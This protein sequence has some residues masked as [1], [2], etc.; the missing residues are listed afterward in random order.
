MI[1]HNVSKVTT[2]ITIYLAALVILT[3]FNRVQ[4]QELEK[5]GTSSYGTSGSY[6]SFAN[7]YIYQSK[8]GTYSVWG[9][10][11]EIHNKNGGTWGVYGF[12]TSD[13]YKEGP[14]GR[15]CQNFENNQ[16]ICIGGVEIGPKCKADEVEIN[17]K[18]YSRVDNDGDWIPRDLE[19]ELTEKYAPIIYISNKDVSKPANAE[20]YIQLSSLRYFRNIDNSF[21][22]QKTINSNLYSTKDLF[23]TVDRLSGEQVIG[24]NDIVNSFDKKNIY[25]HFFLDSINIV[26]NPGIE[27]ARK[28]EWRIYSDVKKIEQR[29]RVEYWWFTPYNKPPNSL[30]G[31]HEG[32]WEHIEIDLSPDLFP[33]KVNYAAHENTT[34]YSWCLSTEGSFDRPRVYV[35]EG[36]H[37]SFPQKSI[38]RKNQFPQDIR[39]TDSINC[40][41]TLYTYEYYISNKIVG[42]NEQFD[43][44]SIYWNSRDNIYHTGENIF[45]KNGIRQTMDI[46]FE[47][48]KNLRWGELNQNCTTDGE[49]DKIKCGIF[50]GGPWTPQSL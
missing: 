50:P 25:S 32:D 7:G 34:T 41:G 20:W 42:Q 3:C 19:L 27:E 14:T 1:K 9:E 37:A 30:G 35:A 33:E 11:K 21:D 24:G 4:A 18:C 38:L 49:I 46:N 48:L 16:K 45:I 6:Q 47:K 31:I 43:G 2:A 40:N 28:D 12:P 44:D 36:T 22:M 15:E 17:E 10:I 13:R 26:V 29:F 5:A 39:N 23:V 8:H